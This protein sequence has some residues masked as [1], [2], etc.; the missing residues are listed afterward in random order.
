MR[1]VDQRH[2]LVRTNEVK[3]ESGSR[4]GLYLFQIT[5]HDELVVAARNLLVALPEDAVDGALV[6]AL[7]ERLECDKWTFYK[8]GASYDAETR[9]GN[10]QTSHAMLTTIHTTGECKDKFDAENRAHYALREYGGRHASD[11]WVDE[12]VGGGLVD[13]SAMEILAIDASDPEEHDR[14]LE[15]FKAAMNDAIVNVG[16]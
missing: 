14:I 12:F 1:R 5:H 13:A 6:D 7:E 4:G 8:L 9:R 16:V 10:F 15:L 2:L 3:S 11:D